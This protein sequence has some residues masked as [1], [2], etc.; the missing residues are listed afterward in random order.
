MAHITK[1]ILLAL[2]GLFL[3]ENL[4][5]QWATERCPTTSNLN[6]ISLFDE[7]SGWIVGD[8][9]T[10]LYKFKDA[11]SKYPSVTVENLYSVCLNNDNDG[12]AVGSNGTILHFNGSKWEA[13][14]SPTNETLYSVSFRDAEHG[15]AVGAYGTVLEYVDGTWK[16]VY[17]PTIGNLY[18]VSYR[19][20]CLM[21]GGGLEAVSIP[22]MERPENSERTFMKSFDPKLIQIKSLAITNQ[23]K[24]WAVGRPGAIFHFNGSKWERLEQFEKLPSLNS[25]CFSDENKGIAVG[26]VGTILTYS[27]DGWEKEVSPVKVKFNGSAVSGNTFYA[28]G[29]KGT[30]VFCKKESEDIS[31]QLLASTNALNIKSF[32]NPSADLLNI[33]IPDE[34]GFIPSH[35]TVANAYGQV[36][37]TEK[38]NSLTGGQLYEVNTSSLSNG[39]YM[40][41]ITSPGKL[42][43]SG[44]FIVKH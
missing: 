20:Y 14:A 4:H 19:R 10:I 9:G 33:I 27:K 18:A 34:S 28:V 8:N 21:I 25:V 13:C 16:K 42:T 5:A 11:W 2:L 29:N 37:F 36:I 23:R 7:N 35:I 17:N 32:P 41:T 44:K 38:I 15:I 26:Y 43:A 31:K 24:V 40:V 12:W 3:A 6:S 1:I 39:L 22:V 30:I